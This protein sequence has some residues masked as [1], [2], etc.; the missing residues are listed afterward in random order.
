MSAEVL[1]LLRELVAGQREMLAEL[2]ELRADVAG[3]GAPRQAGPETAALLLAIRAAVGE[4]VFTCADLVEHAALPA[5]ADL[6]GA[7]VA[8]IGSLQPRRIGKA[9]RAID[10]CDVE[11]LTVRRH[12]SGRDGVEWKVCE[13]ASLKPALTVAPHRTA[14]D[15]ALNFTRA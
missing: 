10:G 3:R 8:A 7:I 6:Q 5:A 9:L 12:G 1:A 2:R 15:D 11:G 13:F 4:Y 14:P